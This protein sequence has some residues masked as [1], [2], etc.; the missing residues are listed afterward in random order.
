MAAHASADACVDAEQS[1]RA[2]EGNAPPTPRH[3]PRAPRREA[4]HTRDRARRGMSGPGSTAVYDFLAGKT[5]RRDADQSKGRPSK[6]PARLVAIAV[7]ER[8]RLIQGAKNEWLVTWEDVHEAAKEKLKRLGL[9]TRKYKMPSE[10][11][12]DLLQTRHRT[13]DACVMV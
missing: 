7:S 9:L 2:P 1:Q 12:Q 5:H 4:P 11:K 6:V 10:I 13:H 3:P 8:K